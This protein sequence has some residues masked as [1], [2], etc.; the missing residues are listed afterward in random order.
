MQIGIIR[1][2]W[3]LIR[4][5]QSAVVDISEIMAF[6]FL[7]E[8]LTLKLEIANKVMESSSQNVVVLI[9]NYIAG[10]LVL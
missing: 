9:T 2:W 8:N 4:E 1:D 3:S 10:L 7:V 5:Q 6:S